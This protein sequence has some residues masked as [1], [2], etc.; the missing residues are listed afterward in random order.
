MVAAPPALG[1][2]QLLQRF[3]AAVLV[4]D[5]TVIAFSIWLA[6]QVRGHRGVWGEGQGETGLS[7][8]CLTFGP[9]IGIGWLGWLAIR[10]GYSRKVFAAGGEEFSRA[11]TASLLAAG[12]VAMVCY[13]TKFDLSRGFVCLTFLIGTPLLLSERFAARK[14]LHSLRRKGRMQHR[15]VVLGDPS[16]IVDVAEIL[17]RERYVGYTV[18]GACTSEV[19]ASGVL[20]SILSPIPVLG[21]SRDIR[22]ISLK[23]QA[24]AVLV[25]G[26]PFTDAADVRRT[27]WALEGTDVDLI[28]APSLTDIAGPRVHV[29]PVAGL[30]LLHIEPPQADEAVRWGK[31]AFDIVC[32]AGL[33]I[34]GLPIWIAVALAIKIDDG[35]PVLF[36]QSRVGLRGKPFDCLKFRSMVPQ[37]ELL[38]ESL[39]SCNESD[40]LLFK[41]REDPRIT[42][43]GRFIRRYSL[44]EIPQLVNVLRGEMSLVGPR[45]PLPSEVAGYEESVGRRLL[46]RPGMTGL[47]QISGR[48]SLSWPDSV[49]LDLYYVDNWSLFQDIVIL[50]KTLHAVLRAQGAS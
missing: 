14:L 1:A 11:F 40:G 22:D 3:M 30:P 19:A 24:D 10:G 12:T 42:N 16:E 46:V 15:V 25:V 33:L 44:D 49:R 27:A 31:R 8:L 23:M 18:L 26:G 43:A 9:W 47:W 28:V 41:I 4:A 5:A 38:R 17:R 36:R 48:S 13:L 7:H 20:G 34:L 6:C 2:R 37:A 45:P 29:R 35:G 21:G 50:C 32:A 39:T